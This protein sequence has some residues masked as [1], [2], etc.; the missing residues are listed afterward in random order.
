[1]TELWPEL[2]HGLALVSSLLCPH[3]QPPEPPIT[4]GRIFK[5]DSFC[6]GKSFSHTDIATR[7]AHTKFTQVF[8]WLVIILLRSY[9][10]IISPL[11]PPGCRFAPTCSE[12]SIEAVRAH[13]LRHGI[14]LG[15]KRVSRCHPFTAAGY[16]PVPIPLQR[17]HWFRSHSG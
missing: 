2:I 11:L 8:S 6:M 16:D 12:Y 9:R 3:R 7:Q 4:A 1:M 17:R 13:G 5:T 15:L 10:I 14:V